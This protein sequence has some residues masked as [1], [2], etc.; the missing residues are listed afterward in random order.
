MSRCQHTTTHQVGLDR[1]F[2]GSVYTPGVTDE[3]PAAYG[4]IVCTQECDTCGSQR[5]VAVNGA[6]DEVSAWGPTRAER[7][8]E[9]QAAI[10]RASHIAGQSRR[11][12]GP[13]GRT[14]TITVDQ[15]GTLLLDGPH[16]DREAEI[17]AAR[18]GL[19]SDAQRL[20][21]SVLAQAAV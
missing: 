10:A 12:R 6:H 2:F 16:D 18:S 5:D 15:D 1:G 9:A 3:N 21:E 14:V 20:R 7:L 19:L 4:C 17:I 13:D 8:R 11:M